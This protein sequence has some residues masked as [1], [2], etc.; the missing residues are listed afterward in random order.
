MSISIVIAVIFSE[1]PLGT[2]GVSRPCFPINIGK[3]QGIKIDFN[4]GDLTLLK[5]QYSFIESIF[6]LITR[7]RVFEKQIFLVPSGLVYKIE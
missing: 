1:N 4:F 3:Y 2:K 6:I 5:F 7:L